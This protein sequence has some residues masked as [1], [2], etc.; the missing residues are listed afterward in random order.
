MVSSVDLQL[1]LDSQ[2]NVS[3]SYIAMGVVQM[4]ISL[5]FFMGFK[6]VSIEGYFNLGSALVHTAASCDL[7]LTDLLDLSFLLRSHLSQD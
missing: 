5:A 6:G 3:Q 7:M 2:S 4:N 1:L